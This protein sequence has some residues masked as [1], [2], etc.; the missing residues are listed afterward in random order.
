MNFWQVHGLLFLFFIT[1]FPRLA[2]IFAVSTPFG[3]LAWLAWLFVPHFLVAVLATTFYWHTNPILC[4][5]S[6]FVAFGGTGTEVKAVTYT[7][8]RRFLP[9]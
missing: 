4:V 1:F 7:R 8:P 3:L 9:W 6:W 5:I 2:M